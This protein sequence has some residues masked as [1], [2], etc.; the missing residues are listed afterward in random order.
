MHVAAFH[1]DLFWPRQVRAVFLVDFCSSDDGIGE[2]VILEDDDTDFGAAVLLAAALTIAVTPFVRCFPTLPFVNA[3]A[4]D[5][6]RNHVIV[7]DLRWVQVAHCKYFDEKIFSERLRRVDA[8]NDCIRPRILERHAAVLNRLLKH[9]HDEV[10]VEEV[11]ARF[12]VSKGDISVVV[13]FV[14]ESVLANVDVGGA[15]GNP[16]DRVVAVRRI[17][18]EAALFAAR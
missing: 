13:G 9:G 15:R 10:A 7:V 3:T 2:A 18:V 14:V 4:V 5:E 16:D 1:E 11:F 6:A 17:V 8:L 12:D